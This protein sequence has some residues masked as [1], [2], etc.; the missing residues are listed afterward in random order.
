MAPIRSPEVVAGVAVIGTDDCLMGVNAQAALWLGTTTGDVHRCVTDPAFRLALSRARAEQHP[1]ELYVASLP[2][3]PGCRVVIE[4]MGAVTVLTLRPVN[5]EQVRV[6]LGTIA[7]GHDLERV[8]RAV[9]AFGETELAPLRCTISLVGADG[10]LQ[11]VA[12]TWPVRWR[13]LTQGRKAEG[14]GHDLANEN[15]EYRPVL[16]EFETDPRLESLRELAHEL[17]VKVCWS[18]PL[19][20]HEGRMQGVLEIL[21]PTPRL[22]TPA[23]AEQLHVLALYASL[24]IG[25]FRAHEELRDA[26]ERFEL[27]LGTTQHVIYDWDLVND[28]LAW[29]ARTGDAFGHWAAT[30]DTAWWHDTIHPE[31]LERVDQLLHETLEGNSH[32]WSATYRFRRASGGWAWVQDAGRLQRD[33]TG[34]AVRLVGVMQDITEQRDLRSRLALSERLASVG[35]LAA[36]VAHEINNPLAWITSNVNFALEEFETLKRSPRDLA[37][38]I[39]DMIDALEDA[40][41]GAERVSIIVRDLKTF[42]RAQDERVGAIDVRR[43]LESAIT[44]AAN[45]IR[46]RARFVREQHDVPPVEGNEGRLSQVFL[47]LLLNA[48]QSLPENDAT[49]HEIRVVTGVDPQGRVF[50]E[51][52]DTGSGIAPEVLPRIFDPFFT[53]KPVGQ[54]TGLGLSICHSIITSMGGT[55]EVD[56]QI[57]VG[58]TFRVLLPAKVALRPKPATAQAGERVV[59]G[60]HRVIVIDDEPSIIA[61]IERVLSVHHDVVGFTSAKDALAAI[62]KQPPDV[63][64]CDLMM[65]EL[66]GPEFYSRLIAQWP[67]LA[68][69]VVFMTGGAFTPVAQEFLDTVQPPLLDKPFKPEELRRAVLERVEQRLALGPAPTN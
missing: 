18:W 65:P 36:G 53:T 27:V 14:V 42:S 19:R 55:I 26:V 8:L 28:R 63:V 24:A 25:K 58:S 4:P 1:Q 68:P 46:H 56:S 13:D 7:S 23:E 3:A 69:R 60:R 33:E 50:V 52:R 59:G 17:G 45:E 66:S 44:M 67:A 39:E 10:R 11:Q 54:G 51:V 61:S 49:R 31:D 38:F 32:A 15:F 12:G 41:A 48:A 16:A 43:V 22:P 21:S 20:D 2:G 9:V 30:R 57:G 29:N 40:R 47:N 62:A 35:T 34:K 37:E 5:D 64:F 6:L